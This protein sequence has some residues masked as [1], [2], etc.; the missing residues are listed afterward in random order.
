M[1]FFMW[2]LLALTFNAPAAA[3]DDKSAKAILPHCAAA[4]E[5]NEQDTTGGRCAGII[6]TLT[7]VSR[8]LPDNLKFCQPSAAPPEQVLQAI[9]AFVEKNPEAQAQDFRLVALAAMRAKWPCQE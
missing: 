7:F 9:A 3:Q 6:A 1:R 8:V 5:P 4:L 2:A